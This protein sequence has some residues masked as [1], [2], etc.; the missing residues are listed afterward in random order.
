MFL[1]QSTETKQGLCFVLQTNE[2]EWR[3]RETFRNLLH[4]PSTY[5]FRG[6]RLASFLRGVVVRWG[7]ETSQITMAKQRRVNWISGIRV[8]ASHCDTRTGRFHYL[9]IMRKLFMSLSRQCFIHVVFRRWY[10]SVLMTAGEG[11]LAWSQRRRA[12]EDGGD[13]DSVA[14]DTQPRHCPRSRLS[15]RS[16]H[17]ALQIPANIRQSDPHIISCLHR[18]IAVR[19]STELLLFNVRVREIHVVATTL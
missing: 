13:A 15:L 19:F 4:V 8:I 16:R 6:F 11:R 7:V 1:A 12:G 10:K 18:E 5:Y 9:R 2:D 17:F 14:V 3:E